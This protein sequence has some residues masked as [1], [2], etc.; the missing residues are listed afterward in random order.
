MA[1]FNAKCSQEQFEKIHQ[2]ID[3]TRRTSE[4]VKVSRADLMALLLD[5]GQLHE[6]CKTGL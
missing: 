6:I 2:Q 1:T 5:H 4:T 3:Q